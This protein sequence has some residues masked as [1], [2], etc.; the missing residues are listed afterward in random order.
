MSPSPSTDE[1]LREAR[2]PDFSGK[3]AAPLLFVKASSGT[4]S[5]KCVLKNELASSS[6]GQSF[7]HIE[8][9]SKN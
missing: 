8:K 9:I 7:D 5:R 3:K 4:F 6:E 1:H 2:V